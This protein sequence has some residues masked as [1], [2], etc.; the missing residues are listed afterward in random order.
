MVVLRTDTEEADILGDTDGEKA[1]TLTQLVSIDPQ[2]QS[3]FCNC[4]TQLQHSS[5]LAAYD[6]TEDQHGV[7][8]RFFP[9]HPSVLVNVKI[10][11]IP[12]EQFNTIEQHLKFNFQMT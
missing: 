3:S 11:N 6:C 8:A 2:F 10:N 5:S 1:K 9:P 7:S 12:T 4:S